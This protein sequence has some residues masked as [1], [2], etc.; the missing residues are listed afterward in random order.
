MIRSNFHWQ[1]ALSI[2]LFTIAAL[3]AAMFGLRTY[4]SFVLLRSAYELGVTD[5]GSVR[6]WMTIDY[7]ARTYRVP[8]TALI[9]RL[10]LPL[11]LSPSTT[12]KSLADKQ[13]LS[14]L[15]YV[16]QVQK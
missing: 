1:R 2:T 3:A 13:G 7:V 4:R 14:P 8:E 9:E 11:D 15:E 16:Q 10:R 12:L 6:P 5:V